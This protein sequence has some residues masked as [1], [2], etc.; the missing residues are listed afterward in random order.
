[1]IFYTD[2]C[3]TVIDATGKIPTGLSDGQLHWIG[4][5]EYCEGIAVSYNYSNNTIFGPGDYTERRQFVGKYCRLSY[6][7]V[8]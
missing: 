8:S 6:D 7:I 4:S 3:Y 5:Y 2:V 1:M